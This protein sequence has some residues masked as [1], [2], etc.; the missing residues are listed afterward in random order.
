MDQALP[1]GANDTNG[2]AG[3]TA[4]E[5]TE[6]LHFGKLTPICLNEQSL[7]EKHVLFRVN[8]WSA[9]IMDHK[10]ILSEIGKDSL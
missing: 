5:N 9:E 6:T 3:N 10:D 2:Q 7:R 1:G 4:W 8:I